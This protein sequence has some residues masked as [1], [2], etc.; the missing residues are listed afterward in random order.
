MLRSQA[1][2]RIK[3]VTGRAGSTFEIQSLP[4]DVDRVHL[5]PKDGDWEKTDQGETRVPAAFAAVL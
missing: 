2:V 5:L 4:G 3:A 1:S